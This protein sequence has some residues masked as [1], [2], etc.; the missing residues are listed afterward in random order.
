MSLT[1]QGTAG[2]LVLDPLTNGHFGEYTCTP[3]NGPDPEHDGTPASISL[4]ERGMLQY[5]NIIA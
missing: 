5:C 2:V 3:F 4:L 1:D